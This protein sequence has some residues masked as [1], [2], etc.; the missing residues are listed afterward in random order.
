MCTDNINAEQI[1]NE[2]EKA[3]SSGEMKW[4]HVSDDNPPEWGKIIVRQF[5]D[6]AGIE[7][8]LGSVR[9]GE[10][11]C[12]KLSDPKLC[13]IDIHPDTN[14][15]LWCLEGHHESVHP[16]IAL[17]H[18]LRRQFPDRAFELGQS[19]SVIIDN[20]QIVLEDLRKR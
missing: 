2:F 19:G 11:I 12:L 3:I 10:A 15:F 6:N 4:S 7:W 20:G 13:Y 9:I 17:V 1:S 8:E 14:E 18:L 16:D 5:L